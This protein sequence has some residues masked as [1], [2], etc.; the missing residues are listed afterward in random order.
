LL[1]VIIG[2]AAYEPETAGM[3]F[4]ATYAMSGIIEWVLGW[5][6]LT[7]DDEIFN[8]IVEDEDQEQDHK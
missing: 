7:D 8:A 1:T 2:F 5:K 6:S 4:F 3:V